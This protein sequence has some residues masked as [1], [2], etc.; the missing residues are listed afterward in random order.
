MYSYSNKEHPPR[1]NRVSAY[2]FNLAGGEGSGSYFQDDVHVGEWI[3]ATFV[4]EDRATTS[5]PD[6]YIAIYEDGALRGMVS[7]EQFHVVPVRLVHPSVLQ[8]GTCIRTSRE[9]SARWRYTMRP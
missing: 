8:R 1:P 3:M 6:G 7:L 4:V 2:V 5:W 9:Q